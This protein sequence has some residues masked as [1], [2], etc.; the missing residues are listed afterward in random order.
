MTLT[1]QIRN[2]NIE[3]RNNF[4]IQ[5]N[6]KGKTQTE[7][8]VPGVFGTKRRFQSWECLAQ[9]RKEPRVLDRILRFGFR[10]R[11]GNARRSWRSYRQVYF[12]L[13]VYE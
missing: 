8:F 1:L 5:I 13:K 7:L 10:M 4:Q 6:A 11:Q 12:R 9:G 2:S 3:I